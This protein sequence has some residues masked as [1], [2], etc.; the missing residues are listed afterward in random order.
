MKI[1]EVIVSE[2]EFYRYVYAG[3][4]FDAVA[5]YPARCG[6]LLYYWRTVSLCTVL[7]DYG[8]LRSLSYP[9]FV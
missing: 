4:G 3:F 9:L 6:A 2:K 7:R 1:Q 8:P 5:A